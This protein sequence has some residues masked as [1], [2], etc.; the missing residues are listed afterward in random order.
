MSDLYIIY[1]YTFICIIL[2]EKAGLFE[3]SFFWEGQLDPTSPL[4]PALLFHFTMLTSS[5]ISSRH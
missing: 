2:F 4:Y 3:S 5:V 1:I